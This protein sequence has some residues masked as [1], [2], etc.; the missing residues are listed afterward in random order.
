[1]ILT[2]KLVNHVLINPAIEGA[3]RLRIIV[4]YA[5]P[6]MASWHIQ[7]LN[8]LHIHPIDV[9]LIVGMTAN[10]GIER[11]LHDGFIDVTKRYKNIEGYSSFQCQYIFEG[12]PVNSK[13]YLWERSGR[14]V[15][16][17][18]GSADYTQS[19][20]NAYH[21][22]ECMVKVERNLDII[23]YY[24]DIEK[25]SIFCTHNQI[26]DYIKIYAGKESLNLAEKFSKSGDTSNRLTLSLLTSKGDKVGERS[27]LNWGQRDSREKNQAYIPLPRDK[28]KSGFFPIK[29][30][31]DEKAPHFTV[32]T[33]DL[34][35]LVLRV[36]QEGNKAITTPENNS[37][38][39]E[40]F[41]NRLSLPNGAPIT[42]E[43]LL[44]YGRTD[45]E[46]IK[47]DEEQ[48]YMD[49]SVEK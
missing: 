21:Q 15:D 20:F 41:R 3:D 44:R 36:E 48:Y 37:R 38:I 13:L 1:M 24:D 28:A 32:I 9:S 46:F 34:K 25:N 16:V 12:P 40:Y 31:E 5:T 29:N 10:N 43:D 27:G 11:M 30:Q 45:V 17:F 6:Q 47:L 26:E 4:G 8:D 14:L 23:K 18:I 42:K 22:K 19:S 35:S 7:K 2:D 39:G 33:D 49:F